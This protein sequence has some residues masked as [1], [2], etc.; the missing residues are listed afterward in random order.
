[1]EEQIKVTGQVNIVITG[2]DGSVKEDLTVKNLVVTTGKAFIAGSML[3]TTTNSPAAMTH[4]SVGSGTADTTAGD[5]TLG[6]ELG[7]VTF[8]SAS[9]SSASV[10]YAA[11]FPAGTG[12]GALTE[13]GIFNNTSGGT[14]LCRTK[15]NVVNKGAD[16]AMSITWTVTVS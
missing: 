11:T 9:L 4:M 14:M 1:M 2:K 10:I 15:F 7:R 16:D 5:T 12:T 6:N 13:A 8:S 3:K